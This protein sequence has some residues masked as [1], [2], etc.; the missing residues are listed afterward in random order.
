M[1]RERGEPAIADTS[2]PILEA[3]VYADGPQSPNKPYN[4]DEDP[5]LVTSEDEE[6]D[7]QDPDPAELEQDEL[8]QDDEDIA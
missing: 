8:E 6:L 4:P 7:E 3:P 5:D 1:N 2:K